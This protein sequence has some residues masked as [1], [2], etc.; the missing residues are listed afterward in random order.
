[1]IFVQQKNKAKQ[2]KHRKEEPNRTAQDMTTQQRGE[3]I[4]TRQ[5]GMDEGRKLSMLYMDLTVKRYSTLYRERENHHPG[6][7]QE[8][9][10]RT[11]YMKSKEFTK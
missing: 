3:T 5:H 2:N 8:G 1:M 10:G 4:S 11:Q 7:T 6:V 9:S